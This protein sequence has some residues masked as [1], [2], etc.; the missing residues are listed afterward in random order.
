M[1]DK[2]TYNFCIENLRYIYQIIGYDNVL[3]EINFIHYLNS[4]NNIIHAQNDDKPEKN[5]NIEKTENINEVIIP[6]IVNNTS[7]NKNIIIQPNNSKYARTIISD[8]DRCQ[9]ILST[10]KRCTLRKTDNSSNCSR[11]TK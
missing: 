1:S 2:I 5:I 4:S 6:E 8:E 10:G 9:T 7:D 11:H 3:K